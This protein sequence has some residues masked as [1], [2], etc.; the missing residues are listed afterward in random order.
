MGEGGGRVLMDSAWTKAKLEADEALL[1]EVLGKEELSDER[2]AIFEDM[3]AWVHKGW[4]LTDKQ[5]QFAELAAGKRDSMDEEYENAW[6]AGK[7]PKGRDVELMV[8]DKPLRSPQR[9]ST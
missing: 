4:E 3:L 9:R 6:S 5:R 2:R 8:K 1:D 7:V